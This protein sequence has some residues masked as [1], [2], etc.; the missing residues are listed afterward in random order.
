MSAS[1]ANFHI[2]NGAILVPAFDDSIWDQNAVDVLQQC[3][4]YRKII[5]INTREVLLGGGNIHC[6]TQQEL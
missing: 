5:P 6:I 3:F 2:I 4:P 1:Y